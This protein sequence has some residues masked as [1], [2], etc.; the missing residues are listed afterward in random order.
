M[1]KDAIGYALSAVSKFAGSSFA[2][3]LKLRKPVEKIAYYST[4]AGFQVLSNANEQYQKARNMLVP[5]KSNG[6]AEKLF[7]LSLNAEQQMVVESLKRFAL[8]H[9]RP[10][11]AQTNEESNIPSALRTQFNQLG[12]LSGAIPES[13]GGLRQGPSTVD[14]VL[15]YEQLAYGDLGLALGLTSTTAAARI[16]SDWGSKEQQELW[17]LPMLENPDILASIAIAEATP[18]FSPFILK[19]T[20]TPNEHG[21]RLTGRKS[22]VPNALN[23]DFLIVAAQLPQGRNQLFLVD[24]SLQGVEIVP[25]PGMGLRASEL[26]QVTFKDV[27]LEHITLLGAE[28]FQYEAFINAC[29]LGVCALA[30][31]ASQA[32][33][34]Y[35]IDYANTRTTFGEPISHRQS[36]AFMLADMAIDLESMRLLTYRAAARADHYQSHNRET[37]LAHIQCAEKS[38]QIASNGIQVLG[39]HGFIKEHPVE[40]WYRD[41]RS[42]SSLLNGVSV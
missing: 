12:L 36:I 42:I 17:L 10:N 22:L 6:K 21:F 5:G 33:L 40:R 3:K 32:V 18:L 4:R 39:G 19:T 14:N 28:Q 1:E 11:A 35:A 29:K 9:L 23:A 25:E 26:S 37:Y 20:A 41:L 15:M 24:T 27:E 30:I 34:D 16:L 7:D 8:E 38:M 13:L 31:G 2:N